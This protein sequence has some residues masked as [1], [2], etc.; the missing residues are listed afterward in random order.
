M[1]PFVFERNTHL[2]QSQAVTASEERPL[3][4]L[5]QRLNLLSHG[6]N[7]GLCRFV[8]LLSRGRAHAGPEVRNHLAKECIDEESQ[9]GA[10][11]GILG[12]VGWGQQVR[13]VGIGQE[14]RDNGGFGDDVAVV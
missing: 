2:C 3:S 5:Q 10:V 12:R 4:F 6:T 8:S 13:R 1:G 9:A 14:L 11:Q 7:Q